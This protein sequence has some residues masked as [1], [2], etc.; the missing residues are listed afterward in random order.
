MEERMGYQ[1][2]YNGFE[3]AKKLL[4][5]Q[6]LDG[7]GNAL[8]VLLD[9]VMLIE[10]EQHLNAKPYERS[11]ERRGYANGFKPKT[12]ATRVG[13]MELNIPQ[14]RDSDFYPSCLEKGLRSERALRVA[15]AEMYIQGVS[16]R[17]VSAIVEEMCGFEVTSAQVSRAAAQLDGEFEQWRNRPLGRYK[18]VYCDAR[19]ES[20]RE[21]GCVVSSAVL[22]AI[23]VAGDGRREILG[24]WVS[25]SEAEIHW[26]EFFKSLVSRGL[27]GVELFISDDHYGMKAARKAVFSGT[28]WQRCQFHLQQNAQSYVPKQ[29]MKKEVA[30]KI[31]SIF[32]APDRLEAERIL[33][34]TVEYYNKSAPQLSTW[35]ENNIGEGLTVFDFPEEHQK[36][37]RT[38]NICERLNK[39]IKRR[40]RVASIFPNDESCL[41]LVTGILM[42]KSEEWVS[43]K[44]Y[45]KIE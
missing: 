19:Y 45:M 23:G 39:E 22:I 21:G 9:E 3:E 8:K 38:S 2:K 33:R 29:D 12:V 24:V 20:V 7:L 41:R 43:G 17:K 11:Q 6:G 42:E 5:N 14:V 28:K 34:N 15:M 26:R 10:R 27:H 30:S 44:V 13:A 25:R 35:M 16:T 1:D 37:L 32:N 4:I 18:Y 40:T 36:K 31:R